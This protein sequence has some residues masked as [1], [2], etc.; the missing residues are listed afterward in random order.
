MTRLTRRHFLTLS[1]GAAL[2]FAAL[3]R[4]AQ[5][6]VI[7]G[8][9]AGA[10]HALALARR[11]PDLQVSLVE[12]DPAR[13]LRETTPVFG[14]PNAGPMLSELR[15]AGVE[16]LI[17]EITE[18]DWSAQRAQAFSGRSLP[19]DR[20]LLA[21]GTAPLLEN[22][23]GLTGPAR[24]RWPAAWGSARE[25]R[26]LMANLEALPDTGH[27]VLRLPETGL[28]HPNVA[29]T[30]AQELSG[31]LARHRP[32]GRLTVLD[33]GAMPAPAA[34]EL[35]A[36]NIHWMTPDAGGRVLSVDA[37][38]GRID[39]TAGVIH[40]DA[41]NFVPPLGAGRIAQAAGLTD[42][43]YWCPTDGAGYSSLQPSALILGD[44]RANANR[45]LKAAMSLGP[46]G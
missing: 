16:I 32:N 39:T 27:V 33:G 43:S 38:K 26:R 21:P 46:L 28:A 19:F 10:T 7:G 4:N 5:A 22:I 8:G 34:L 40:A 29:L 30:R 20:L 42:P 24:H 25:A 45:G 12:R 44:A 17:D 13:L 31:W 23:A 35:T 36:S 1:A 14:Q 9:P 2:G 41:V 15:A 11:R 18:I 37:A 6:L 3:P